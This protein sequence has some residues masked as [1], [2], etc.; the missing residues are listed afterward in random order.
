MKAGTL[1]L[2]M[3]RSNIAGQRGNMIGFQHWPPIWLAAMSSLIAATGSGPSGL[4]AKAATK[5]IPIV[6][7]ASDPL[8]LGLVE[9][10]PARGKRYGSE[11]TWLRA[12]GKEAA[13]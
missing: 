13:N 9:P 10:Q 6:F 11:P 8:R 3:W 1:K 4:S 5:T 2:R 7:V 12:G